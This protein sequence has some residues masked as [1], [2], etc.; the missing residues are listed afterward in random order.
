M[1][2][3]E[4]QELWKSRI[5]E[6]KA[7]GQGVT[8]WCKEYDVNPQQLYYWLRKENPQAITETKLTWLPL[9]VNSREPHDSLVVRFGRVAVEVKPGFDPKLLVDVVNTLVTR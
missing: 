9:E 6:F 2:R 8:K 7:S 1:T 5:A 4:R 3:V